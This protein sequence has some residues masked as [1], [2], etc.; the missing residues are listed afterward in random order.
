MSVK[1]EI[2]YHGFVLYNE[3]Y[4]QLRLNVLA[5]KKVEKLRSTLPRVLKAVSSSW[6]R[7]VHTAEE[8]RLDFKKAK[9]AAGK[10]MYET[11]KQG[12]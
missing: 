10:E 5:T 11:A 6:G 1:F 8:A 7:L 12:K 9:C 3:N 2:R 4:H